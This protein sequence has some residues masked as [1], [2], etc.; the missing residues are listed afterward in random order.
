MEQIG[1]NKQ[2]L[3]LSRLTII[4]LF[5]LVICTFLSR[6]IETAT[7]ATVS[8]TSIKSGALKNSYTFSG[9][10]VFTPQKEI[11]IKRDV[12]VKKISVEAGDTINEGDI[13]IEIDTVELESEKRE[14]ELE[15]KLLEI[16]L[17]NMWKGSVEAKSS[18]AKLEAAKLELEQ[19]LSMY[20]VDGAIKATERGTVLL[21]DVQEGKSYTSG[22]TLLKIIPEDFSVH[23]TWDID[24]DIVTSFREGTPV[25]VEY[26]VQEQGQIVTKNLETKIKSIEPK[27]QKDSDENRDLTQYNIT[28]DFEDVQIL[29]GQQ[30]DLRITVDSPSYD[31]IIPRGA[32]FQDGVGYCVYRVKSREGLFGDE[33]Y[34][35]KISVRKLENN[36]L[37][38]A[39]SFGDTIVV[40]E[41]IFVTAATKAIE[42][43][44]RVKVLENVS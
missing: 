36:S 5:F 33:Y 24:S 32:L 40:P 42:D 35:E 34:L 28:A 17:S 31:N 30:V 10:A 11:T 23:I 16:E 26:E 29:Q 2:R 37:S 27:S 7:F 41:D 21:I 44:V 20:P 39:I 14:K 8:V 19:F 1:Q 3:W 15:I 38:A 22:T 25:T 43:N 13:L 18:L 6:T 9:K 12:I 4:I